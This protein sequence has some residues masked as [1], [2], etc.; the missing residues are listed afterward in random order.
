MTTTHGPLHQS[1]SGLCDFSPPT[2]PLCV[3]LESREKY[4]EQ[5]STLWVWSGGHKGL[6][7]ALRMADS[8]ELTSSFSS[9]CR[10]HS[11]SY[12]RL[13]TSV[14]SSV[15]MI[16]SWVSLLSMIL[17]SSIKHRI[18]QESLRVCQGVS[19]PATGPWHMLF[20]KFGV[21][22]LSPIL[23]SQSYLQGNLRFS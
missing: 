8:G 5:S 4:R 10:S 23:M 2:L 15:E 6:C 1:G 18:C 11:C 9:R 17:Y 13:P 20:P 7:H 21:F 19:R 3:H 22:C 16:C 12:M 14:L